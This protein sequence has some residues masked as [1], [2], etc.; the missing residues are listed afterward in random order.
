MPV[1]AGWLTGEQVPLELIE[2]TLRQMEP[3]L[4]AHGGTPSRIVQPGMGLVTFTDE[5]HA[6]QQNDEPPVLDWVPDRRTFVYRRPLSGAHPLYYVKD[7]PAQGNLFFASE[8][9]AL[10]AVGVSRK[11]HLASLDALLHFGFIPAPWTAFQHISL[12]PAGYLLRWQH[13]KLLV[14]QTTDFRFATSSALDISQKD[15]VERLTL[16]LAENTK[17][18]LPP[19]EQLVAIINGDSASALPALLTSKYTKTPY[20]AISFGYKNERLDGWIGTQRVANACD[21]SLLSVTGVDSPEFWVGAVAEIESPCIDAIPLALQQLFN[22]ITTQVGAKVALSS[23]GAHAMLNGYKVSANKV[24][25][26]IFTQ[27]VQQKIAQEAQWEDTIYAERLYRQANKFEDKQQK[28]YYLSLHLN[29]ANSE[30]RIAHQIAMQEGLALRSPYLR[31]D[32]LEM[33]TSLDEKVRGETLLSQIVTRLSPSL[34]TIQP[35]M[36]LKLPISSLLRV[37]KSDLLQATLLRE[38]ILATGIFDAERV[39]QLLKQK[40]VSRELILVFTTQLFC[41]LFEMEIH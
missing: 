10:L 3:V 6:M 35:F 12:V 26:A 29:M 38:A 8:I 22:T 20:T 19:H 24:T 27:E 16:L 4:G 28:Q 30:V 9:K 34:E 37:D 14:N 32:V 41:K 39:E 15:V 18:L 11:L 40:K 2:Q 7:W 31:S 5:A 21:H 25:N 1:L 23:L 13:A 17:A 33:L 36:P